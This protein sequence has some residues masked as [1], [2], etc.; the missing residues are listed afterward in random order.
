MGAQEDSAPSL[1][2]SGAFK[3]QDEPGPEWF[4]ARSK[5]GFLSCEVFTKK[6]IPALFFWGEPEVVVV[7]GHQTAAVSFVPS[8]M[9]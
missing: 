3:N 5:T 6:F 9:W 4:S 7:G 8:T 1:G 2:T